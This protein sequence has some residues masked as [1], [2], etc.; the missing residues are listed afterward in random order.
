MEAYG[1]K[2][3]FVIIKK[4]LICHRDGSIRHYSFECKFGSYYQ[5][6]KQIDVNK[7]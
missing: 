5:P 4:W 2:N 6:K 7:H 1:K 3:G